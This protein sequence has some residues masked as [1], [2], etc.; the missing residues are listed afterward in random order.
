MWW[1]AIAIIA[2]LTAALWCAA[3]LILAVLLQRRIG[4]GVL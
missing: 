3:A 2:G 4:R 1:P